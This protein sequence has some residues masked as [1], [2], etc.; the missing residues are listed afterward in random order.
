MLEYESMY[1]MFVK[2]KV[3]NKPWT[4]QILLNIVSLNMY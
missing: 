1:E 4:N 3:F 2:L